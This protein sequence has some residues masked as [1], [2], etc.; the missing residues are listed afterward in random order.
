MLNGGARVVVWHDECS[1]KDEVP[2]IIMSLP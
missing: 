2:A 1:L